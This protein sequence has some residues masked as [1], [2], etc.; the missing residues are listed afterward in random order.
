MALFITAVFLTI[1]L[2]G[3]EVTILMISALG[4]KTLFP[5]VLIFFIL[6]DLIIFFAISSN[7]SKTHQLPVKSTRRS[8][9]LAVSVTILCVIIYGASQSRITEYRRKIRNNNDRI[10]LQKLKSVVVM[11]NPKF[12]LEKQDYSYYNTL[13][14]TADLYIPIETNPNIIGN[15]FIFKLKE[16]T[17]DKRNTLFS[18]CEIKTTKSF[19]LENQT[20]FNTYVPGNYQI[21]NS[22]TFSSIPGSRCSRDDVNNLVGSEIDVFDIN[23]D[24]ITKFDIDKIVQR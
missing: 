15:G 20:I 5:Y 4:G 3:F 14:I 11:A 1:F 13:T 8:V 16:P 19:L 6:I 9:I 21:S 7:Y 24:L 12:Y 18:R 22:M 23:G 10:V 2:G 17:D